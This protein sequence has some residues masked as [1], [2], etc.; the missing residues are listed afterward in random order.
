M[1]FQWYIINLEEGTVE[2]TNDVEAI[3]GFINS[4]E[5]L[6]LTAQHGRY[7]LGSRKENEVTELE[8]ASDADNEDD[9]D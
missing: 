5:Y 4:D 6:I 9:D 2:G 3:E 7:F 1:K 8:I